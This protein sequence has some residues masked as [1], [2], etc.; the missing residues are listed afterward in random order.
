MKSLN[1]T[2]TDHIS[3]CSL[4]ISSH[5]VQEIGNINNMRLS[6]SILYNCTAC[7]HG[8]C[9]HDI[10]SRTN[11]NH[12]K[13]NMAS[14]KILSFGNDSTMTD[15]HISAKSAESFQMLVD[16]STADIT[17]ARKRNFCM[18]IFSEQCAQK[19]IRCSD[20][21]DKFIIYTEIAD[22]RTVD[23]YSRFIYTFNLG[24]DL[25]DC[26]KENIDISYIRQIL[27]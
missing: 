24:T 5:T 19:I 3:T 10:D 27:N 20:L 13:E 22:G 7:C 26:L 8:S 23:L 14:V 17:S 11:R 12:I 16:R 9:H 21:L 15:I 4:D 1:T 25:R 6:R 2:D 18:F